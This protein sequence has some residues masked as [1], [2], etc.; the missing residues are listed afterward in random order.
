ML[1]WRSDTDTTVA[2]LLIKIWKQ[3]EETLGVQRRQNGTIA[4]DDDVT[5]SQPMAVCSVFS[6]DPY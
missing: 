5:E 4:G 1:G 3:E 2:S 6:I